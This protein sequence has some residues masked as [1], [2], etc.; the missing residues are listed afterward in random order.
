MNKLSLI[1]GIVILVLS[2]ILI[3]VGG[4]EKFHLQR[5]ENAWL[6]LFILGWVGFA[7]GAGLILLGI[8]S[9]RK[10]K[11]PAA[12]LSVV[13]PV[14]TVPVTEL[15]NPLSMSLDN[16]PVSLPST[17]TLPVSLPNTSNLPVS[18]PSTS[19]LTKS[20]LNVNSLP[21]LS[22]NY[23][24]SIPKLPKKSSSTGKVVYDTLEPANYPAGLKGGLFD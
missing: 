15:N 23:T 18:L 9:N 12:Q 3:F 21:S 6:V 11:V 14:G 13:T 8:F 1:I 16:I 4:W 2:I 17:S 5:D 19:T 22:Y 10:T 24:P 7:A 20:I